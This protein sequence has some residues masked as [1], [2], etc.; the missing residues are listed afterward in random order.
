MTK[1]C[2]RTSWNVWPDQLQWKL[3]PWSWP[4]ST[5]R[6]NTWACSVCSVPIL[7][8]GICKMDF[9][10]VNWENHVS[11]RKYYQINQNIYKLCELHEIKFCGNLWSSRHRFCL[12]MFISCVMKQNKK[13][14]YANMFS[15]VRNSLSNTFQLKSMSW[16][17]FRGYSILPTLTDLCPNVK[18]VNIFFFFL[19]ILTVV[20][21]GI[22]LCDIIAILCFSCH[23]TTKRLC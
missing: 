20:C 9:K 13:F 8:G 17:F 4:G 12:G 7:G 14:N 16:F 22:S 10:M 6:Q 5:T 18:Q 21:T 15:L 3:Q 19:L 2:Q 23:M 11:G 1:S